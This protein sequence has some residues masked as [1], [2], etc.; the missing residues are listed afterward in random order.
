MIIIVGREF[1]THHNIFFL[2]FFLFCPKKKNRILKMYFL[3]CAH[4]RSENFAASHVTHPGRF[5]T[6][7]LSFSFRKKHFLH[8]LSFIVFLWFFFYDFCTKIKKHNFSAVFT[9]THTDTC[10]RVPNV[11]IFLNQLN[12]ILSSTFPHH[13]YVVLVK[14][15]YLCFSDEKCLSREKHA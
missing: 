7:A 1:T 12:H 14:F 9:H 13:F 11:M 15:S 3:H 6:F 8:A 4:E 2:L 5:S 10:A